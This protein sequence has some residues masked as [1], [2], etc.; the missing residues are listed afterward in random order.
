MTSMPF[1]LPKRLLGGDL[2]DLL[3]P[4][5][6]RSATLIVVWMVVGMVLEMVSVGVVVPAL[7]VMVG[8]GRLL[9]DGNLDDWRTRFGGLSPGLILAAG[10]LGLFMIYL[11]TT[12]VLAFAAWQQQKFIASVHAGLSHRLYDVYLRQP[13][14]FH[15]QRNSAVLMTNLDRVNIVGD[16]VGWALILLA[17][18][19][20]LAGMVALLMWFEP[21]GTLA[22]CGVAGAAAAVLGRLTR[23]RLVRWGKLQEDYAAVRARHMHHG[24]HGVKESLLRGSAGFLRQFA[25]ANALFAR[26]TSRRSF[27][28]NLPRLWFE[29]VAV[30]AL[31]VLTGAMY[32]EG[33][34]PRTMLPLLG[35]FAVAAFRILPSV[36]RLATATHMLKYHR[37]VVDMMHEE[38]AL[39]RDAVA[40]SASSTPLAF[41]RELVLDQVSYRYPG[42]STDTLRDISVRIPAGSSVGIMGISGAGKSTL[43]DTMLGLLSPTAGCIRADGVDI[44]TNVGGWQRLVGYVPQSIYLA[45]DTIC[46]NVA[47]GAAD[48]EIDH[49]A[50]RR[51]IRAAQLDQFVADLPKGLD[52]LVGERGVRLSGGQR[53]RIGIARALYHDPRILVL[54]EATS[55]LDDAT[56]R[57]ILAAVNLLHGV[58]TLVIVAHRPSTVAACETIIELDAGRVARIDRRTETAAAS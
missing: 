11:V 58:K 38:L 47:F 53:Q 43:I 33:K 9:A 20:V 35:L 48:H 54:D 12:A 39:G 36:N 26:M 27:V 55:A 41:D 24:I 57:E 21:V 7:S 42:S 29:L 15:L 50:V 4:E 34:T 8:G 3:S 44:A 10:L 37:P 6:R 23:H 18:G 25:A 22:V 46:R 28:S 14:T 56:E 45:D 1:F 52:T 5:E 19:F 2:L 17:E 51:A 40:P 13:W 30:T 49:L 32:L 31:C 16:A